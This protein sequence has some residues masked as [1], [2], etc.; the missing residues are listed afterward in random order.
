MVPLTSSLRL[1]LADGPGV[2]QLDTSH[3]HARRQP[4]SLA[5]T[6]PEHVR[7]STSKVC[8]MNMGLEF[9][10]LSQWHHT[11]VPAPSYAGSRPLNVSRQP[12]TVI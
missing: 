12:D 7:V 10:L 11:V 1:V 6:Q 8:S 3:P 2:A 4:A 9:K 5:D